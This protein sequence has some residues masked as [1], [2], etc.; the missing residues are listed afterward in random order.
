MLL[1]GLFLASGLKASALSW[2]ENPMWQILPALIA[3]S[4][5]SMSPSLFLNLKESQIVF[6]T[7]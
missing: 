5:L 3:F 7:P 1:P 4:A 6:S 2:N